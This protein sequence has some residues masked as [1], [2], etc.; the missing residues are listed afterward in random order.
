MSGLGAVICSWEDEGGVTFS[1]LTL[2]NSWA[3]K[4]MIFLIFRARRKK[5][6]F[7]KKQSSD[8]DHSFNGLWK[9]REQ[10][11]CGNKTMGETN[12]NQPKIECCVSN[13]LTPTWNITTHVCRTSQQRS[14]CACFTSATEGVSQKK[15]KSPS[16]NMCFSQNGSNH[17]SGLVGLLLFL[18]CDY[19]MCRIASSR[20][21]HRDTW[22]TL[23]IL[24]G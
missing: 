5:R 8:L 20:D 19:A 22:T 7:G 2:S 18:H 21:R 23:C 9:P 1:D 10:L 14:T 15:K 17:H 13:K 24:H 16:C 11:V 12:E 4:T 3:T 6:T